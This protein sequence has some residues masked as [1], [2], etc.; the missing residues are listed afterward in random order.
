MNKSNFAASPLDQTREVALTTP[1]FLRGV[2]QFIVEFAGDFYDQGTPA[3]PEPLGTIDYV[4]LTPA[5][6]G[7][8]IRWYGMPRDT[9]GAPGIQATD[10]QPL[11]VMPSASAVPR[12]TPAAP[13]ATGNNATVM[14]VRAANAP[15]T[16]AWAPTV[17]GGDPVAATLTPP[18][19][20]VA[21]NPNN[22]RPSL[23]RITI[24]LSD[25]NGRLPDGQRIEYVFNLK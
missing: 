14:K 4:P 6:S 3:D 7:T 10:V 5:G 18:A 25:A 15:Y 1:I 13:P 24:E 2:T 17:T 8:Q 21:G 12:F 19:P 23:I 20:A 11:S 9:D 16:F 22:V